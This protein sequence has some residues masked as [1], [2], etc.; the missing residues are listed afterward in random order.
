MKV[1]LWLVERPRPGVVIEDRVML[2]YWSSTVLSHSPY[3]TGVC[4]QAAAELKVQFMF[5]MLLKYFLNIK[6][7]VTTMIFAEYQYCAC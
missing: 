2:A 4:S 3:A 1:T 6:T 7:T 5:S